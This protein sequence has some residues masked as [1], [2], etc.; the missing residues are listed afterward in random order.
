M[1]KYEVP[2]LSNYCIDTIKSTSAYFRLWQMVQSSLF[3]IEGDVALSPRD[4]SQWLTNGMHHVCSLVRSNQ[5]GANL[6][7][8]LLNSFVIMSRQHQSHLYCVA[9]FA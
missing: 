9:S 6:F 1:L 5:Y 2:R 8:P 7:F 3:R 4:S